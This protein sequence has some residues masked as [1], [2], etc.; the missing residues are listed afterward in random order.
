MMFRA[1]R[2]IALVAF[3]WLVVTSLPD[4]ARFL[5]MRQM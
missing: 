3:G 5:R 4:V 2:S 1:L